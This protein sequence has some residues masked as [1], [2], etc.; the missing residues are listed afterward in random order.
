MFDRAPSGHYEQS[1]GTIYMN[2][3]KLKNASLVG[4]EAM[5]HEIG[6]DY[7]HKALGQDPAMLELILERYKTTK[8]HF[9]FTE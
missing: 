4:V 2:A 5:T 1:T 8:A 7:M 3:D 9:I 6:H